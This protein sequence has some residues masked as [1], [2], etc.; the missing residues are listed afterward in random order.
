MAIVLVHLII[1][2]NVILDGLGLIV[3]LTVVVTIILLAMIDLGY[4]INVKIGQLDNFVNIASKNNEL[5]KITFYK[6]FII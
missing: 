4:V 6:Y 2:V 5:N 1:L 3:Q